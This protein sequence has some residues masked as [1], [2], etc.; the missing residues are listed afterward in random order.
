MKARSLGRNAQ[1]SEVH[2][3]AVLI[4]GETRVAVNYEIRQVAILVAGAPP[5]AIRA[6]VIA[7]FVLGA[8]LLG[9]EISPLHCT[10]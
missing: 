10:N 4:K 9:L 2:F 8:R 5:S 6:G 1:T 7:T 3:R